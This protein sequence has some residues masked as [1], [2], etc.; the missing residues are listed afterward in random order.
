MPRILILSS[1]VAASRVGGGAQ[2]LALARLGIEPVLV[3]TVLYGRHPGLGAAGGEAVAPEVFE[4]LIGGVEAQ[5]TFE[6]LDAVI[7]GHFSSAQQ[8]A[9]AAEALARVRAAHPAARLVVD[10]IMGDAG[11][12]LYVRE[13]VA[14]AI[15][16]ELLPLADL[17]TPNAWELERL[18]GLAV[19]GEA[20]ALAAAT[21]LGRP[22]LVSSVPSGGEVGVVY[23]DGGRGWLAAHARQ[24]AAPKGTG[25]LLTAFF[26]A[27]L[28]QGFAIHDAL[29]AAVG[30]LA[31][32]IAASGADD[33]PVQVLPTR[34]AA[35]ARVRLEAVH[36]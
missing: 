18:S 8:V 32:V 13:P 6:R 27:A 29:Q 14:E 33:P 24:D 25:D 9:I 3:P 7:T 5:G 16:D 23:A 28:V 11:R 34:L 12:G 20:T 22:V 10:P 4:A 36:G 35:S 21:R 17:V 30:A 26:T 1:F 31:E 19:S 15:A 2:V